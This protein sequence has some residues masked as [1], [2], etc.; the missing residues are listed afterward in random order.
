MPN[1]QI[2]ITPAVLQWARERAGFSLEEAKNHFKK[3]ESWEAGEAYPTYPQLEQLSE[4]F[5]I[6]IAVFFF[7][8]PPDI[9]SVQ[10]TFRT[11][12]EAEFAAMPRNLRYLLRKAKAFQLNLSELCGGRNPSQ[13]TI[14]HEFDLDADT[15]AIELAQWT[16]RQIGISLEVQIA[17]PDDDSA[18]KNWRSALLNAG[19]F[20]F[21]DPFKAGNYSGFCLYDDEFPIVYVNSSSSKTRQ[22]FTL[23]HELAHLLFHTSG[24]DTSGDEYIETLGGEAKKIEVLCNR[25]AA[26][27]LLPDEQFEREIEG[28]VVSEGLAEE[29]ASKFHISR[30]QVFRKFLDR[31]LIG[32]AVYREAAVRWTSQMRPGGGG[33]HYWNK[34]SYLGRDYINL[35][36]SQFHQNKINETQLAEYLDTKPKNVST[37]E[38]YFSRGAA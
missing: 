27:F 13:N 7:P 6:P 9:P 15:N 3:I 26:E 16:R 30:E 37:L 38:E 12:P 21:K 17:W 11:L 23:F 20:V 33:D 36:L 24:I 22:I 29:I 5:K 14:I 32:E 35:A 28:Q 2:L 10:E 4:K 19:V 1:E 25:F 18:L 31:G 8:A 34:I